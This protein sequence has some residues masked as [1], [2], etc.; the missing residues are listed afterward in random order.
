MFEL[1]HRADHKALIVLL[2]N[3]D[4]LDHYVVDVPAMAFELVEVAVNPLTIVYE[5]AYNVAPELLGENDSLG[6]RIPQD[7]FAQQLCARFGKPLVSTSANVSGEPSPA[8]FAEIA[9]EI[10]DG[11]DYVVNHRQDDTTPHKASNIIRLNR[12]GTFKIIR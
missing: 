5:G 3:V 7:D 6:V 12:N 1:K 10:V 4:R 2:D 9:K 8:C 11:V